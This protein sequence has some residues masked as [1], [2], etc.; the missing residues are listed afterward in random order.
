MVSLN[1]WA[2]MLVIGDSTSR[3]FAAPSGV[4]MAE[5][6]SPTGSFP[7][8]SAM[9][10]ASRAIWAMLPITGRLSSGTPATPAA[11]STASGVASIL[12]EVAHAP[13]FTAS[14]SMSRTA[15]WDA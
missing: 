2:T 9:L 3:T 14:T 12:A 6:V 10:L 8:S 13:L 5:A 15:R 4:L 7:S 1:I 11:A